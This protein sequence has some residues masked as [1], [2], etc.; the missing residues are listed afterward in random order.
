MSKLRSSILE[1]I[2]I[3]GNHSGCHQLP[4]RSFFYKGKQFPVCARCTG[5]FVGEVTS[6]MLLL[7]D[8][9][10]GIIVSFCLLFIMGLDWLIQKV[11]LIESTNIRRLITGILGGYGLINIYFFIFKFVITLLYK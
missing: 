11:D 1:Q 7:I 6:I 9:T 10:P 4:E 5:V 8:I 3:I 2:I